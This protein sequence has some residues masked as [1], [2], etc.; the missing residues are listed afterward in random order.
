MRN[1]GS[2]GSRS[3][4]GSTLGQKGPSERKELKKG[5]RRPPPPGRRSGPEMVTFL[6]TG[7]P[8]VFFSVF[9]GTL[10][11]GVKKVVKVSPKAAI[12]EGG[13]MPEV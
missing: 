13:D 4:L 6:E 2:G 7:L 3:I 11:K 12:L 5:L 9:R 10:E 1:G 8:E